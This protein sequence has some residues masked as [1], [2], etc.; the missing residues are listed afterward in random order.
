M[1]YIGVAD[2]FVL[3]FFGPVAVAGSY[4]VQTQEMRLIP[5]LAGLTPGLLSVAVLTVN[6]LRDIDQD[7]E[8][9]K[10]TLAVR[11]G[12]SF[13]RWEYLLSMVTALVI[14]PLCLCTIE[15]GRW[16]ALVGCVMVFPALRTTQTV[17][18]ERNGA[19]LNACLATTAKILLGFS[20]LFSVGWL[21]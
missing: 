1:G 15:G 10:K 12:I 21:L 9:G 18:R 7:R 17:F 13:A 8:V 3:V 5:L 20:L 14:V 19:V 11:F 4:Y 6:N 2:L 16:G